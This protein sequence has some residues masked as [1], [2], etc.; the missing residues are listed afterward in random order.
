MDVVLTDIFDAF[1]P[2]L[3]SAECSVSVA[4]GPP[5]FLVDI[6]LFN[7]PYV[8]TGMAEYAEV[9]YLFIHCFL[10]AAVCATRTPRLCW[11]T[12]PLHMCALSSV[13]I[14]PIVLAMLYRVWWP[15]VLKLPGQAGIVVE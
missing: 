6:L 8:P 3:A 2:S 12:P 1:I 10:S 11:H 5:P 14:T 9:R 13:I 4:V 7:P 15:G